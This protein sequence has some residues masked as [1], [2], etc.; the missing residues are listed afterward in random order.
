M[1]RRPFRP[2]SDIAVA[3]LRAAYAAAYAVSKRRPLGN[4]IMPGIGSRS[5]S[6]AGCARDVKPLAAMLFV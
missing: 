3:F 1:S 6:S 2:D 5:V 4:P